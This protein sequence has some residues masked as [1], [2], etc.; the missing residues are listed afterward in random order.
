[1]VAL[2]GCTDKACIKV[3]QAELSGKGVVVD[4]KKTVR[5]LYMED[6]P[7]LARILQK[8]MQRLGYGVDIAVNGEVGLAMVD[9]NSYDIVMVDYNMPLC[10]GIDV[11]RILSSREKYPPVIMVT[12]NGNEKIAV[13]ALKLGATDYI[14]K[15]VDMGYLELLPLV[16]EQVIQKQ[17][18]LTERAQMLAE[19]EE[20][21]ARYRKLVELSPDGIV[22]C[23]R[24]RFE[25][26]NPAAAKL[27]GA[28]GSDELLGMAM[29]DFVH[30]DFR[31]IFKAQLRQLEEDGYNVPWIEERFIR[32]DMADI[33]VEVS[34]VPFTFHGQPAVQIIFRDITERDRK[35]VV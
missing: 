1:M 4:D 24:G 26:I 13:D 6:D 35:S 21:E 20:S 33:D 16:V 14:V 15:D 8:A 11:L 31:E 2:V 25:F 22:I 3:L 30:P 12:G 18:L 10:G 9:E 27:L 5:I 32:F 23:A 17:Q 29:I 28:P 19:V 7:G 34:G